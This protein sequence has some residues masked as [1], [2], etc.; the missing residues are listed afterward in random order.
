MSIARLGRLGPGISVGI[1]GGAS[2]GGGGSDADVN[3]GVPGGDISMSEASAA[4]P[5]DAATP[6]T[7]AT[8]LLGNDGCNVRVE[9]VSIFERKILQPKSRVKSILRM[10]PYSPTE[11]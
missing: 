3:T 6:G 9:S 10:R 2:L 7:C 5:S 11:P 4:S 8:G 1:A